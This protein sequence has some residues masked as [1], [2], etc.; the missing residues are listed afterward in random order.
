MNEEILHRK[1][2]FAVR[3]LIL[4]TKYLYSPS[5]CLLEATPTKTADFIGTRKLGARL[6]EKFL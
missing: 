2:L 5:V 4:K 1:L 6:I 3:C